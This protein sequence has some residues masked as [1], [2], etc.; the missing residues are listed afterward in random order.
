MVP[1][2]GSLVPQN[3][4]SSRHH[5]I[6]HDLYRR[7]LHLVPIWWVGGWVGRPNGHQM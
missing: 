1:I 4:S 3:G 6:I 2:N 7:A 5:L